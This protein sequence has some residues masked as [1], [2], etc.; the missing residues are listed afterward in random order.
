MQS[1]ASYLDLSLYLSLSLSPPPPSGGYAS[2]LCI[3]TF[4]VMRIFVGRS[5]GIYIEKERPSGVLPSRALDEPDTSIYISIYLCIYQSI[6]QSIYLSCNLSTCSTPVLS[7]YRS[8]SIC[9]CLAPE[10]LWI[11]AMCWRVGFL[12]CCFPPCG[13]SPLRCLAGA[14][15]GSG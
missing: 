13:V 11:F 14:L 8:L 5:F 7:L 9:L 4:A 3:L 15:C 1:L 12:V 10:W 6:N 2:L